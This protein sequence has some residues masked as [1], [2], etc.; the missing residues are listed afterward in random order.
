MEKQVVAVRITPR[1][2][3]MLRDIEKALA[4]SRSDALRRSVE[5]AHRDLYALKAEKAAED[6]DTDEQR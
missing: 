1:Q 6:D 4:A 5:L 3:R 2:E